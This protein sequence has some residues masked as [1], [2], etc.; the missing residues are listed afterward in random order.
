MKLALGI[1]SALV[2]L[3]SAGCSDVAERAPLEGAERAWPLL[4]EGVRGADV[5]VA[6]R[7]LEHRGHAISGDRDGRFGQSTAA[8]TRAFQQLHGLTVDGVI[9][10]RTWE[11]L[12]DYVA[13]GDESAAVRAL[14]AALVRYADAD[15]AAEVEEE[16][17]DER[18]G[19]ATIRALRGEQAKRCLVES[20]EAGIYT[21][22][23]LLGDFGYC[24]GGPSAKASFDEVARHARAAGVPCGEPLQLAVA[25]AAAE[26]SLRSTAML[27]NPPT[28]G[29][30]EGSYDVGAWQINDC[31]HPEVDHGCA[32][33]L[34]C[35]SQAMYD[36]SRSGTDWT[37]WTTYNI[38]AHRA[39]L[40]EASAAERRVC[41]DAA[42]AATG[43]R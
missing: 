8:Q 24:Q 19:P 17:R 18:A 33:D 26:S 41:A 15:L 13:A 10:P 21:W 43:S 22:S 34:S 20:G 35:A 39:F 30:D 5:S 38:G 27:R 1:T 9:G 36:V 14:Q 31:Y 12:V 4:R 2:L 16:Q 7:L 29:C 37:P 42:A 23:A 32:L 28:E 11:A 3:V 40:D 6:Q 25:I